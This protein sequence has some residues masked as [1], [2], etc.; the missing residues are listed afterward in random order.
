MTNPG[1]AMTPVEKYNRYWIN[2]LVYIAG[3]SQAE[4]S[5]YLAKSNIRAENNAWLTHENF[6]DVIAGYYWKKY[7][8]SNPGL[9]DRRE[10]FL[11]A[12]RKSIS[13][14]ITPRTIMCPNESDEL[15]RGNC[16]EAR[17]EIE[18]LFG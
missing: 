5:D 16:K 1:E 3:L 6:E 13:S 8:A 18:S 17:K 7:F 4:A 11:S 2:S 12:V 15:F 14:R 10:I 9:E